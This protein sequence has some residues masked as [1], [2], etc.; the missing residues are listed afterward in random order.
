MASLKYALKIQIYNSY[1]HP[2][3]YSKATL[4]YITILPIPYSSLNSLK[5]A[6]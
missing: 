5:Y 2:F 1:Y 4:K 6:R 3:F